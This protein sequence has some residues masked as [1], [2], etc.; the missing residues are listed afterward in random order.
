MFSNRGQRRSVAS[1][2]CSVLITMWPGL[3]RLSVRMSGGFQVAD[4]ADHDDVRVL[5][6]ET[7]SMPRAKVSPPCR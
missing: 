6:Q 2:V 1:F 5:P 4:F 7:T 3:G